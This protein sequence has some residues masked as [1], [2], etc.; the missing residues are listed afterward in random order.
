MQIVQLEWVEE[1]QKKKKPKKKKQKSL[2]ISQYKVTNIKTP[3]IFV[4]EFKFNML[5][6]T[7]K[8]QIN[9]YENENPYF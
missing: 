3:Y 8:L 4:Q 1:E 6:A 9:T 7:I 2:K 5:I